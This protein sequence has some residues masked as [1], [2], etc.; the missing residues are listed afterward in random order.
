MRHLA[1]A[2]GGNA[3]GFTI[4]NGL[5]GSNPSTPSNQRAGKAATVST[6]GS[7]NTATS[8]SKRKHS[9]FVAGDFDDNDEGG[10]SVNSPSKPPKVKS[11]PFPTPELK[12]IK[13]EL[14]E[15]GDPE[16]TPTKRIRRASSR[17]ADM[18]SFNDYDG[19]TEGDSS[20][21]ELFPEFV[22]SEHS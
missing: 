3:G 8:S 18:V 17:P 15:L 22:K 7:K 5:T 21:S 9:E 2:A 16:A 12:G 20:C 1:K 4:Q 11:E 14:A 13:L 6:P 10:V 19:E